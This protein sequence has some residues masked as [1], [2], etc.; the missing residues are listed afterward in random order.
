MRRLLII[1]LTVLIPSICFPIGYQ[2]YFDFEFS[3]KND[4]IKAQNYIAK[5]ETMTTI[6]ENEKSLDAAQKSYKQRKFGDSGDFVSQLNSDPNQIGK[7]YVLRGKLRLLDKNVRDGVIDYL[8]GKQE[9][10][11]FNPVGRLEYHDCYGEEGR[12]CLNQV[13]DIIK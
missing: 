12:P 7:P 13:I 6:N 11:K 10:F 3:E 2:V 1:L 5:I 9:S 4:L 8:N